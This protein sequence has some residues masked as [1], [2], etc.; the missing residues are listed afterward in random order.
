MGNRAHHGSH[1][2]WRYVFDP[3]LWRQGLVAGTAGAVSMAILAC[4]VTLAR[5]TTG[6]D[7]Y[8]FAKL[9]VADILIGA[10]FNGDAPVDYRNAKGVVETVS[11]FGLTHTFEAR[12]ARKDILEAAW[13]GATLG[14]LSGFGGA[15]LCLVLVR[16]SLDNLRARRPGSDAEPARVPAGPGFVPPPVP[17]APGR[18]T[19]GRAT[20]GRATPGR[21]TPDSPAASEPPHPPGA[22][23]AAARRSEPGTGKGLAK[24]P[25]R[26]ERRNRD[27][28][29]WV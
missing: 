18:A 10:G 16:R 3:G 23:P 2:G 29:R 28:G 1:T 20:P 15:L 25:V 26:R 13:E 27:H 6:H 22:E 9:T 17:A 21:A 4:A 12:W 19:P 8:A 14:A 7:W 24:A 5:N 11:R